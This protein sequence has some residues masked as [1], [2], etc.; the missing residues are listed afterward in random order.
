MKELGVAVLLV[1]LAVT[2]LVSVSGEYCHGWRDSRA[3]WREGFHCPEQIDKREAV[4]CC[5]HCDLRYCCGDGRARLNQ[6]TCTD[7]NREQET[8]SNEHTAEAPPPCTA[9][10]IPSPGI[11]T[12]ALRA[13]RD[14]A[15]DCQHWNLLRLFIL[16]IPP[17]QRLPEPD[18]PTTPKTRETAAACSAPLLPPASK[19]CLP[20]DHDF[21]HNA[22]PT[23]VPHRNAEPLY[24]AYTGSKAIQVSAL[25][26]PT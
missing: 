15:L 6:G 17:Q 9:Q 14:S 2:L 24:N 23:N 8:H 11:T 5:G 7:H 16:I 10:P 18:Q 12:L 13:S 25:S 4:L 1:S 22:P 21:T 20:P 26:V 3:Q 19:S